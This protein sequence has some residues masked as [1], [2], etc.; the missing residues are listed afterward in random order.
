MC[1]GGYLFKVLEI[2]SQYESYPIGK[3]S[4]NSCIHLCIISNFCLKYYLWKF[5]HLCLNSRCFV[6]LEKKIVGSEEKKMVN[7]I[8][9]TLFARQTLTH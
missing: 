8:T 2:Y 3:R 5:S 6:S 4:I 1:G 7:N 9:E